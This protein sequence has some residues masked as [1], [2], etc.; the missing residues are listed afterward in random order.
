M[1]GFSSAYQ[2]GLDVLGPQHGAAAPA[3]SMATGMG[4]RREMDQVF[5]CRA[6]DSWLKIGTVNCIQRLL[7]RGAIHS[8]M[9]ARILQRH[10][11]IIDDNDRG[12]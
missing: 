2:Q 10:R 12:P 1:T 8:P 11:T 6:N 7:S 3:A 9:A 4:N 5:T